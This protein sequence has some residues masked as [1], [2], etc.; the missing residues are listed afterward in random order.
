MMNSDTIK[1]FYPH[2]SRSPNKVIEYFE[3]EFD[4]GVGHVATLRKVKYFDSKKKKEVITVA[5]VIWK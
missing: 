4:D 3:E 5:Q 2:Y 1:P